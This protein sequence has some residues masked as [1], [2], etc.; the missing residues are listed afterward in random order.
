M[1]NLLGSLF[2]LNSGACQITQPIGFPPLGVGG[3]KEYSRQFDRALLN[4]LKSERFMWKTWQ[5]SPTYA[6]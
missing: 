5:L 3:K 2:Y 4:S 1:N 6:V